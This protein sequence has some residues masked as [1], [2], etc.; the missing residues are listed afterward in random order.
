MSPQLV[1]FAASERVPYDLPEGST[2]VVCEIRTV[3]GATATVVLGGPETILQNH[4]MV[5]HAL[6]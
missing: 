6:R 3:S 2:A 5:Q 1:S 4:Q